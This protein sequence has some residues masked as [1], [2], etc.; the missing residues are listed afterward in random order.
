M[1]FFEQTNLPTEKHY[2][3]KLLKDTQMDD[4]GLYLVGIAEDKNAS[5]EFVLNDHTGKI[6]IRNIPENTDPIQNNQVIQIRQGGLDESSPH[7]K[8]KGQATF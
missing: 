8:K 6:P 4:E 1:A 3:K 2:E 5:D 7:N